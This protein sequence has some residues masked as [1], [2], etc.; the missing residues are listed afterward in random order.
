MKHL[1][2]GNI[3]ISAD[4]SFQPLVEAEVFTFTHLYE[5]AKIKPQYKSEFDVVKDFMSDSVKVIVTS[6]Q[7]SDYQIQYLRDTQV[8]ARTTTFAYDGIAIVT[9]K[10]NTDTLLKY[11]TVRDIFLGKV[12]NM[13]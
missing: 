10:A 9:N 4:E 2:A 12:K 8:I 3:R 13:E 7:L 6:K 11:S 1:P 5:N